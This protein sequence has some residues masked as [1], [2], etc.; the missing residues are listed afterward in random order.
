MCV[1]TRAG[2]RAPHETQ[3]IFEY[4]GTSHQIAALRPATAADLKERWRVLYSTEPPRR[5][6]RDLLMR[7]LAYRIHEKAL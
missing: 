6:S 7:A 5:I 3:S 1:I 2:E 4:L